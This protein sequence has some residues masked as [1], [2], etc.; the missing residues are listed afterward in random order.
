MEIFSSLGSILLMGDLNA[1]TGKYSHSVCK[2]GNNLIANDESEFSLCPTQRNSFDNELNG[3]G[4]R[5]LEICK[6]ADLRIL[7]GRVSGDSLGR[8]TFHGKNG[9]SVVD[10]AVCDQDLLSHVANFVDK[11]PLHLSDHSPITSWL[12]INKKTSYNHTILEGDT[13]T[14][15][16]KQFL[17]E[18]DSAQK[19]KDTLRSPRKQTL[20]R[21]Q[22]YTNTNKQFLWENDSTQKFK[23]T[24]RSPR[25]Q[26]LIRDYIAGDTFNENTELSLEK[27]ENI[28][29]TTAKCCLKIRAAKTR[30]RIKS[31]SNKK[32][33]DKECRLK[34]HELRK[35]ANKKHQDP[36]NTIIREQYH[37]TLA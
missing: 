29:I 32:R 3:H 17:W 15:L 34:R 11:D 13:L 31:L 33:F 25:I 6:S 2:E 35:L 37:D 10:Y 23:D 30:K 5:L 18:N 26:T 12:N 19:F 36:L 16:P 8:V 22:T 9:V 28:L 27:V 24:L 20:I 4:K 14:R 7:N 21:I 1:R